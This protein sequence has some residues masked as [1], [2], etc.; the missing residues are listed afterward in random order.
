MNKDW[1][2]ISICLLLKS[3][4]QICRMNTEKKE[5]LQEKKNPVDE[6]TYPL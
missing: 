1:L 5:K 6:Q 4:G 3:K 2:A